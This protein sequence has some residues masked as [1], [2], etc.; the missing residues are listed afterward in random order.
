MPVSRSK[1]ANAAA[2]A[3]A[4][5]S[6]ASTEGGAQFFSEHV[7]LRV[8]LPGGLVAQ[9][10]DRCLETTDAALVDA[11]RA[12][13]ACGKLYFEGKLPSHIARKLEEARSMISRSVE[14]HEPGYVR[15]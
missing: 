7:A 3:A 12:G 13:A 8:L 11:L 6:H 15:T 14:T 9:F 4:A 2:P 5:H 10:R 1:A